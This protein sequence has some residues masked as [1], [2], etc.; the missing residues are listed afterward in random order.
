MWTSANLINETV[1]SYP[2]IAKWL[3]QA[4]SMHSTVTSLIEKGSYMNKFICSQ[5]VEEMASVHR[6]G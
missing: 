3:P 5:N 6:H 1:S 2:E 4:D